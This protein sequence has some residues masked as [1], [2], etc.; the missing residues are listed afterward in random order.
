M[1]ALS[2]VAVPSVDKNLPALP[3]DGVAGILT[4]STPSRPRRAT[5]TTRSLEPLK[6]VSFDIDTGSPS[7]RKEKC[8]SQGNLLRPI[9]TIDR[10]EFELQKGMSLR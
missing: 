4:T 2:Q 6:K 10:L 7:K 5:V 1:S 9:E 3:S 8:R